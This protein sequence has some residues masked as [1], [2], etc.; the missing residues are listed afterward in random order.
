[1]QLILETEGNF[2]SVAEI[3]PL[4]YGIINSL[5]WIYC[6]ITTIF[7]VFCQEIQKQFWIRLRTESCYATFTMPVQNLKYKSADNAHKPQV[8][9]CFYDFQMKGS[10][11]SSRMASLSQQRCFRFFEKICF[12]FFQFCLRQNRT[13][14]GA[15]WDNWYQ[16]RSSKS[17]F[18]ITGS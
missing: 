18:P 9:F 4:C 16:V 15:L 11:C 7:F 17:E 5:W 1:M 6:S 13:E 2:F 14:R 10:Y 3:K 12:A 8:N